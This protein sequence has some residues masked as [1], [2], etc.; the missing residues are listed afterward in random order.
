MSKT[1]CSSGQLTF[2]ELGKQQV[3]TGS[4]RPV[5]WPTPGS[6]SVTCWPMPFTCCSRKRTH[7]FPKSPAKKL[8][9]SGGSCSKREP[10]SKPASG[11]SGFT[12]RAMGR[13]GRCWSAFTKPSIV[14][15]PASSP[16]Q[17][18]PARHA[19][20]SG[21]ADNL[22]SSPQP[23]PPLPLRAET[24][25]NVFHTPRFRIWLTQTPS[26]NPHRPTTSP[27]RRK[28]QHQ[29]R[30]FPSVRNAGYVAR[31]ANRAS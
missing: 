13:V 12:S 27:P 6:C 7:R 8:P 5:F 10:A 14:I 26:P 1:D 2:W 28:T 24:A 19:T 17:P 22:N 9:H 29:Q 15:W 21:S 18:P 23:Q 3:T 30:F 25:E 4:P 11:G 16:S 20:C 31:G